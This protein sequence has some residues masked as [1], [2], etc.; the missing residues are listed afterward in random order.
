MINKYSVINPSDILVIDFGS[1]SIKSHVTGRRP[2]IVVN[3]DDPKASNAH[4]LVIPIFR[5]PSYRGGDTDIVINPAYCNGLRY[6]EYANASNIQ[7][8]ERY[9]V[10][11]KIGHMKHADTRERINRALSQVMF[12]AGH[13]ME[14]GDPNE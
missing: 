4:L 10:R 5:S 13:P 7:L 1:S 14:A 12:G 2:A 8:V 9:R 3:V 6:T 11:K